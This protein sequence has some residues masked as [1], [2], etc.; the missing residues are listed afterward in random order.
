[1]NVTPELESVCRTI[2][3]RVQQF[4]LS[5]VNKKSFEA[6]YRERYGREYDWKEQT[7]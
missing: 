1:M 4:M 3:E 7:Q 5:E 2:A 6:W